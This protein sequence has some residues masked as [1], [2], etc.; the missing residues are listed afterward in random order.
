[1]A[2]LNSIAT[3]LDGTVALPHENLIATIYCG[4]GGGWVIQYTD[5]EPDCATTLTK[6]MDLLADA[7]N[8][9]EV[10]VIKGDTN[11]AWVH[12]TPQT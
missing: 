1:M 11:L 6:V 7:F 8:E 9:I 4:S 5:D 10:Y 12:G 2:T 3:K